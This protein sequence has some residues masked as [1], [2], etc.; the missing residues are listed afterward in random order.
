M[1]STSKEAVSR[2]ASS[3]SGSDVSSK[4]KPSPVKSKTEYGEPLPKMTWQPK[5]KALSSSDG[6]DDSSSGSDEDAVRRR[7][8]TQAYLRNLLSI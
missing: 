5:K 7:R 2:E 8:H 6:S 4:H 3:G 1:D